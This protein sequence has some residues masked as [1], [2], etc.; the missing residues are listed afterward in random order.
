MGNE[1]KMKK[2]LII[3]FLSSFLSCKNSCELEEFDKTVNRR[4]TK[5][6]DSQ[7][8]DLW[9]N[10]EN[11]FYERLKSL[12]IFNSNLDTLES[13]NKLYNYVGSAGYPSDYY[14]NLSK[15]D[16]KNLV[17]ELNEIG[18]TKQ[19]NSVHEFLYKITQ[20][21]LTECENMDNLKNPKKD[22]LIATG[23]YDPKLIH[24]SLDIAVL[25]QM[26]YPDKDL[27]RKGLYKAI[28]LF[29]FSR[30]MNLYIE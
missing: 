2:F 13:L 5:I 15:T 11:Q 27:K 19:R 8:K 4:I 16:I 22:L 14:L 24:V 18:I 28:V 25:G 6:F 10:V 17:A 3:I 26:K 20:P 29:Y 12:K 9:N 7:N 1:Q 30:M 23:I 21:V